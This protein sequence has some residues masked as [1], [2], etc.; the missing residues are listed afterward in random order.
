MCTYTCVRVCAPSHVYLHVLCMSALWFYHFVALKARA[1][2][3]VKGLFLD[4]GQ[5]TLFS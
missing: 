5:D 1:S 3:F 2:G 4:P